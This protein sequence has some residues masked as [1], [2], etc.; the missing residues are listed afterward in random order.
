MIESVPAACPVF[1]AW[2]RSNASMPDAPGERRSSGR[3]S[4]G[5]VRRTPRRVTVSPAA[6]VGSACANACARREADR[7]ELTARNGRVRQ[8]GREG[9]LVGGLQDGQQPIV[10][11]VPLWPW[12]W[13][14]PAAVSESTG[15][16]LLNVLPK[17]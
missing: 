14:S 4:R 17:S 6:R 13:G 8:P 9:E 1:K 10:H 16:Y 5:R 11:V 15:I 2:R 7:G 12:C 3:I